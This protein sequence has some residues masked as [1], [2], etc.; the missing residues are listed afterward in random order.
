[1]QQRLSE[2][3][4]RVEKHAAKEAEMEATMREMMAHIQKLDATLEKVGEAE[5]RRLSLDFQHC[6][7]SF[8]QEWQH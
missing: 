4:Q 3:I 7:R 8:M 6:S 1:M 5:P 2:S